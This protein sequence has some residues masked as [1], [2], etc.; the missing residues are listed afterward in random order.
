M[1]EENNKKIN[2]LTCIIADKLREKGCSDF[3]KIC[4]H[5]TEELYS[6]LLKKYENEFVYIYFEDAFYKTFSE[7]LKKYDPKIGDFMPF[8][9][10]TLERR[11]KDE[12]RKPKNKASRNQS[13]DQL[14]DSD[15]NNNDS[16]LD[17]TEDTSVNIDKIAES[18]SMLESSYKLF[19]SLCIEEKKNYSK[20]K[21]V[22]YPPLFFT[23]KLVYGVFN[24]EMF[25]DIVKRCSNKFDEAVVKEFLNT[26]VTGVCNSVTDIKNYRCK[27]LFEFTGKQEDI[28]K[29]CC[30]EKP[31]YHVFNYFLKQQNREISQAAFSQQ[32]NKI[33]EKLKSIEKILYD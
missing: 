29:P 22:C 18:L 20:K 4:P 14:L 17:T 3:Y 1:A 9:K 32:K 12:Y 28:H 10:T 33:I 8:F 7:T 13:L 11:K 31:N 24:S 5:E 16:L 19:A 27:P 25:D 30:D 6:L 2:E 26:L 23:D 21:C 15:G